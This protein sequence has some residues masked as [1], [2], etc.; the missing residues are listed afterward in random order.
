MKI[1]KCDRCGEELQEHDISRQEL[2][3]RTPKAAECSDVLFDLCASCNHAFLEEF[4]QLRTSIS[5]VSYK[6][7]PMTNKIQELVRLA[8]KEK[9]L[10]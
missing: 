10:R 7:G 2:I 6:S 4:L 3:L 8:N 9:W 5:D 1:I